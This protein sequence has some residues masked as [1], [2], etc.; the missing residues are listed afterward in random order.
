MKSA[1]RNKQD[2]IR[3]DGAVLG[4]HRRAFDQRQQ[5]PLDAFAADIRTLTLG[6]GGDFVDFVQKDDAI[7]FNIVDGVF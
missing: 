2:M 7:V 6:T 1:G 3:F 4:R 5:V